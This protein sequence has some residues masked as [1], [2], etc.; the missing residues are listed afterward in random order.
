[1][2]CYLIILYRKDCAFFYQNK[3][4]LCVNAF[5]DLFSNLLSLA[6]FQNCNYLFYVTY[7]TIKKTMK[8]LRVKGQ[9]KKSKEN[10]KQ[11][12][13]QQQKQKTNKVKKK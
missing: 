6:F 10:K 3:T 11:Q 4:D 7:K 8:E 12:Q 2:F 13:Q 1:M 5:L 9:R